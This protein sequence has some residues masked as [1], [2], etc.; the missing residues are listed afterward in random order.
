MFKAWIGAHNSLPCIY[1]VGIDAAI[2]ATDSTGYRWVGDVDA[3]GTLLADPGAP[4]GEEIVYSVGLEGVPDVTLVRPSFGWRMVT[5][6]SGRGLARVRQVGSDEVSGDLGVGFNETS[7]GVPAIRYPRYSPAVEDTLECLTTGVDTHALRSLMDSK[8]P[9]WIIHD[10][11]LC[12]VPGCDIPATQ[13]VQPMNFKASRTGRVD[14][15]ERE[16]SVPYKILNPEWF[17]RQSP[18]V[19]WEEWESWGLQPGNPG[20]WQNYSELQLAQLVGGLV[21]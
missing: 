5:D 19:T 9:L 18:V 10:H 7:T 14:V 6:L 20:G 13:L 1:S 12:E 17:V 2:G 15:A 3:A 8:Q 11:S 21:L 4:A 16:W